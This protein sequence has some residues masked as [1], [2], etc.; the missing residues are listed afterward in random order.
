MIRPAVATPLNDNGDEL[1][2]PEAPRVFV[3]VINC[4]PG[5]PWSQSQQAELEARLGA[6]GK[7]DDIT[8]RVRRLDPWRPGGAAKFAA[9]YAR[10]E[11]ARRGF[12]ASRAVEGR[13]LT[14]DFTSPLARA[15]RLRGAAVMAAV[16]A[17]VLAI[18][19]AV[20]QQASTRRSDLTQTLQSVE[21]LA[22]SRARQAATADQGRRDS[23]QLDSENMRKRRL[24]DVLADMDWAARSKAPAAR[25]QAL[26]WDHGFM[27]VEA[28]GDAPPFATQDRPVEKAKTAVRPGVWL[29][30]VGSVEPWQDLAGQ[31]RPRTKGGR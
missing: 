5:M 10:A 20:I 18:G 4:H 23:S 25:L 11:D 15:V 16:M 28:G 8:Y 1:Q 21:Q 30:G 9:V 26:H 24:T 31:G 27:A 19:F 12:V 3:R 17:A 22:A 2:P 29:W 13:P 6:P 7:L 14:V